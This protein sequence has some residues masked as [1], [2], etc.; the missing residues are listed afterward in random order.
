MRLRSFNHD[1]NFC[2]IQLQSFNFNTKFCILFYKTSVFTSF[3]TYRPVSL[4]MSL[5]M[6]IKNRKNLV[7]IHWL[8]KNS[9]VN[10]KMLQ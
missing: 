5:L 4:F 6:N 7:S 2:I 9:N 8:A 10:D 3:V 1:T